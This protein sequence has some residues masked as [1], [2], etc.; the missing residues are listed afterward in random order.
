MPTPNNFPTRKQLRA[1]FSGTNAQNMDLLKR[2]FPATSRKYGLTKKYANVTPNM[3]SLTG[4]LRSTHGVKFSGV[5]L[6]GEQDKHILFGESN[7][8]AIKLE[9][10][11]G[12]YSVG[13]TPK[14]LHIGCRHHNIDIWIRNFSAIAGQEGLSKAR[15]AVYAV[16]AYAL[17][18]AAGQT[19]N[20]KKI[21]RVLRK[22][23]V[24]GY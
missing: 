11:A 19:Q 15:V 2:M 20:A 4:F 10:T 1:R 14:S 8:S 21:G 7:Y 24:K 16:T 17:Y 6:Y 23:G 22:L 12:M 3:I 5:A 18:I 13:I 9:S